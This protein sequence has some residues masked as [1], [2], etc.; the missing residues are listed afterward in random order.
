MLAQLPTTGIHVRA[1]VRN[2]AAAVL[3]AHVEIMQGDLTVTESLDRCL[4]Q[5]DTVFLVWTAPAAAVEPAIERIAKRARR[6]VLLSAPLQAPHPMFQQPN[7]SRTRAEL[8]ERTIEAS[9]LAWT[10]LQPGMFASNTLLWWAPQI[11]AGNVVRWPYLAAPTAP[12][13]ERDIAAVGVK[14][15]CEDGHAGKKYV[16]T[17]PESLTQ[18]EQVSTLGQVLGRSLQIED[19]SPDEARNTVLAARGFNPVS[20]N[21]L[22]EAWRAALGQSAYVTSTFEELMGRRPR[23]Y[24]QWAADHIEQIQG[25]AAH[26]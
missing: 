19:I 2:P 8:L 17:G 13:D 22:L 11:R 23:T 24:L 3:P 16:L 6:I 1:L 14:A 25:V 20:A 21:Y 7:P 5:V 4:D 12:I 9:G 15:L 26:V 18:F 10:F